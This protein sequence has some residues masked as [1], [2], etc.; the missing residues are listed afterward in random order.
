MNCPHCS[1]M[2]SIPE[3]NRLELQQAIVDKRENEDIVWQRSAKNTN[4]G[5]DRSMTVGIPRR[6]EFVANAIV[7]MLEKFGCTFVVEV[8]MN[9]ITSLAVAESEGDRTKNEVDLVELA[10]KSNIDLYRDDLFEGSEFI[11]GSYLSTRQVFCEQMK[12]L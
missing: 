2:I 1:K 12:E 11:H 8:S 5:N 3:L 4:L 7:A 9:G 10:D 6:S